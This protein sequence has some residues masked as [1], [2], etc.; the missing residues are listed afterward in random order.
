LH[1]NHNQPQRIIYKRIATEST[2]RQG[3]DNSSTK[4]YRGYALQTVAVSSEQIIGLQSTDNNGPTKQIK[5]R[6]LNLRQAAVP[7][8]IVLYSHHSAQQLTKD[9]RK[10]SKSLHP[11]QALLF[12]H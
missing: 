3:N 10:I 4:R 11:Y 7:S 5:S 9:F 12:I 2:E 6:N 1:Y 8:W